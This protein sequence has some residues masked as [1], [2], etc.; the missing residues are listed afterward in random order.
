MAIDHSG[1]LIMISH[2]PAAK[3]LSGATA[4]RIANLTETDAYARMETWQRRL[5][6]AH[7]PLPASHGYSGDG[8]SRL[9]EGFEACTTADKEH[10]VASAGMGLIRG[11]ENLAN[12]QASFA[13][14]NPDRVGSTCEAMERWWEDLG[15]RR[16]EL[17]QP[18]GIAGLAQRRPDATFL[19]VLNAD[20]LDVLHADLWEARECVA[21]AQR[22]LVVAGG[23]AAAPGLG[24]S[25]LRIDSR[26]EKLV[27]GQRSTVPQRMMK[28]LLENFTHAEMEAGFLQH[29]LKQMSWR[30]PK[31]EARAKPAARRKVGGLELEHFVR[32]ELEANPKLKPAGLR[33]KLNDAG[34]SCAAK[35]LELFHERY[36]LPLLSPV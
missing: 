24:A 5:A 10:W 35:P 11:T 14:D 1:S 8:W 19:V 4:T 25:L 6:A 28:H 21:D 27:G 15:I 30:L 18:A 26:F 17:G 2:A 16:G 31:P 34:K 32:R 9:I 7:S 13:L 3:R 20:A 22:F 23:S 12:Y 29:W 33:R 36:D